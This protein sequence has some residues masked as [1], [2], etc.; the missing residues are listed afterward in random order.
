MPK[1]LKKNL[2]YI[3]RIYT[4]GGD[5]YDCL[6]N[7]LIIL[8]IKILKLNSRRT[9]MINN[10][11]KIDNYFTNVVKLIKINDKEYF[12]A[13]D[14]EFVCKELLPGVMNFLVNAPNELA[15]SLYACPFISNVMPAL[16]TAIV[17]VLCN[18]CNDS[19][20]DITVSS[21]VN[22]AYLIHEFYIKDY[23]EY[24]NGV[25]E[26][27]KGIEL[28]M[29]TSE[30]IENFI[31]VKKKTIEN[32]VG[33]STCVSDDTPEA[34][35]L[36]VK[37][38][39]TFIPGFLSLYKRLEEHKTLLS[40][41][42]L[43][44]RELLLDKRDDLDKLIKQFKDTILHF[45]RIN[46]SRRKDYHVDRITYNPYLYDTTVLTPALDVMMVPMKNKDILMSM[47]AGCYTAYSY[48][49][50]LELAESFGESYFT[51]GGDSLKSSIEELTADD[52]Y[53]ELEKDSLYYDE[54]NINIMNNYKC[55]QAAKTYIDDFVLKNKL[56]LY[57]KLAENGSQSIMY[58]MEGKVERIV[59]NQII[60]PNVIK[61]RSPSIACGNLYIG[62]ADKL[63]HILDKKCFTNPLVTAYFGALINTVADLREFFLVDVFKNE[64]VDVIKLLNV[65]FAKGDS[66]GANCGIVFIPRN[67]RPSEKISMNTEVRISLY[68][69]C[70]DAADPYVALSNAFNY[71]FFGN[72][73]NM[74]MD[75]DYYVNSALFNVAFNEDYPDDFIGYAGCMP[76]EEACGQI[77]KLLKEL[78]VRL[79]E[80][81]SSYPEKERGKKLREFYNDIKN[82]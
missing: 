52:S 64:Y 11:K 82:M 57:L 67:V 68:E 69:V 80:I 62:Q 14:M 24:L 70:G 46:T 65:L 25:S 58:Y 29:Y 33:F 56:N 50:Y 39:D 5:A 66:L 16:S 76:S 41:I 72:N 4:T 77:R 22:T 27:F 9:L 6:N 43:V 17:R 55:C 54:A 44:N 3:K 71:R 34:A 63:T 18:S 49:E 8:F 81:N 59:V 10:L 31:A 23:L 37:M 15:Y 13:N 48:K 38:S 7:V 35:Y 28:S 79:I 51:S 60:I 74:I 78:L 47:P 19:F 42:V 36:A 73:S 30:D 2:L 32:P 26:Q 45:R 61:L 1:F 12:T 40:N 53:V 21:V 20:I 75:Y